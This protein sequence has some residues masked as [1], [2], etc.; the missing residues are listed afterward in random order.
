MSSKVEAVAQ[1]RGL[2][3]PPKCEEHSR[4]MVWELRR[5]LWICEDCE[6]IVESE[7]GASPAVEPLTDA[8]GTKICPACLMPLIRPEPAVEP[9]PLVSADER[10]FKCER[11]GSSVAESYCTKHVCE[12]STQ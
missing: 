7:R 2:T 8:D 10:R 3:Q 4:W 5:N 9:E 11:C 1:G 12:R 6:G